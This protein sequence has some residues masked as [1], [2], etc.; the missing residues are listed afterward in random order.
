M[1]KATS[2]RLCASTSVEISFDFGER[3]I[4]HHLLETQS[5]KYEDYRFRVGTCKHCGFM[6]LT[7][8]IPHSVLY[9]DYYTLSAWK[10]QAHAS[11]LVE[12]IRALAATEA[13]SQ[14]LE[15]GCNDGSFLQLLKD[16]GF[17]NV[18][19][20][21]PTND[22]YISADNKGLDV[23]NLPLFS[24]NLEEIQGKGNVRCP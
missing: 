21:E 4:V 2:C 19:G 23:V 15:I 17:E 12:L 1:D 20:I 14:V 8:T 22:A 3:P 6:Q 24:S 10:P 5:S 11:R 16:G 18:F 7:E 9:A 13:S